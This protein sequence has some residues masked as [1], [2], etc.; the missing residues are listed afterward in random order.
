MRP[1]DPK[2][3]F[4]DYGNTLEPDTQIKSSIQF[5]GINMQAGAKWAEIPCTPCN[6]RFIAYCRHCRKYYAER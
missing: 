6:F 5:A 1:R 4:D 2:S 3:G